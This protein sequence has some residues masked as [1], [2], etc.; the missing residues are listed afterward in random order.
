M[1]EQGAP[2]DTDMNRYDLEH[3]TA[4]HQKMSSQQWRAIYDR[5]WHLYYTPKHVETLLRRA[6]VCGTGTKHLASA[7]LAYYGSYR[8]EK[9]HPLQCGILR[10]SAPRGGRVCP[11]KPAGFLSPAALGN[12]FHLHLDGHLSALAG[13]RAAARRQRSAGRGIH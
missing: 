13:P 5:A 9:V 7:I 10:Q 4:L 11:G 2:M 12:H 6:K 3:V 8:F 1:Y